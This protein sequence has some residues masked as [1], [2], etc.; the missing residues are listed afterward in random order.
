MQK[1]IEWKEKILVAF[2]LIVG[3]A[4]YG[5]PLRGLVGDEELLAGAVRD[6]TTSY[7]N[8][9]TA[10]TTARQDAAHGFLCCAH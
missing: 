8:P 7:W 2:A 5:I 3:L 1:S 6:L 4:S 9:T 10:A